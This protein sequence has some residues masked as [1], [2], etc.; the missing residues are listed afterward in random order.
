MNRKE[1]LFKSILEESTPTDFLSIISI[2]TDQLLEECE[3]LDYKENYSNKKSALAKIVKQIVSFYNTFGGYIVYGVSEKIQD[4]YYETCGFDGEI[5]I[6]ELKGAI[7]K[8]TGTNIGIGIRQMDIIAS[9]DTHAITVLRI[10]R[11]NNNNPVHFITTANDEKNNLIFKKNETAIRDGDKSRTAM[12]GA[13]WEILFSPRDYRQQSLLETARTERII[14]HNLPDKNL[15]CPTFIGREEIIAELWSWLADDF[16]Y[17][18]VLAG[19]G[20][21]GK[22]S[23][24]YEFCT[25][26][27][28]SATNR[29]DLLLWMSA[30]EKQFDALSDDYSELPEIHFNSSKSLLKRVLEELGASDDAEGESIPALKRSAIGS[31]KIIPTLIVVDNLDTM[32]IEEQRELLEAVR[33]IADRSQARILLTTRSNVSMPISQCIEVPGLMPGEYREFVRQ[34]CDTYD[35]V[36]PK[37]SVVAQM[38]RVSDGSPLF[39]QS[40]LRLIRL[41]LSPQLA[42]KDWRGIDGL[43]VRTAALEREIEQ[44]SP[45]GRRVLYALA[46][47]LSAS[48]EELKQ[49]SNY[50]DQVLRGTIDQ[51][52]SLF[53]IHARTIIESE[54]RFEIPVSTA[55]LIID[56]KDRLVVRPEEINARVRGTLKKTNKERAEVGKAIRQSLA[57]L[58]AG[59][60]DKAIQTVQT[61]IRKPKFSNNADLF[62]MKGRALLESGSRDYARIEFKRAYDNGSRKPIL[63][64]LWLKAERAS[65][66]YQGMYDVC[67]LALRRGADVDE[68]WI[69]RRAEATIG[70][71]SHSKDVDFKLRHIRRAADDLS[72]LIQNLVRG[73]REHLISDAADL[74]DLIWQLCTEQLNWDKGFLEMLDCIDRGDTRGIIYHR[75]IDSLERQ[76]Q[77]FRRVGEDKELDKLKIR[78]RSLN[79]R[80]ALRKVEMGISDETK[81]EIRISKLQSKL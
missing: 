39:T 5:N 78:L 46:L 20:G 79:E 75:A 34:T 41:G 27:C 33:Q 72:Q 44:L 35:I 19:E 15:I 10:P 3:L 13:D 63:F 49:I 53:L 80:L 43:A 25:Q 21:R 77:L 32:E 51:L 9:G 31:L 23:I 2:N 1:Q 28:K 30:K 66:H 81:A 37:S 7:D 65:G 52:S 61:L 71:A 73:K 42:L 76:F 29:F 26:V 54:R 11:R 6:V 24:A 58:N 60:F 59:Q 40:I 69:Y 4:T 74:H 16:E 47:V 68:S 45:E 36:H 17:I 57:L 18:K 48:Y 14:Q 22:T 67:E 55:R 12:N 38:H 62:L 56:L 8:F 50:N 64:E 70:L